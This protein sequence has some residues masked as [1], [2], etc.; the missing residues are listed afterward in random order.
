[1]RRLVSFPA[2][3]LVNPVLDDAT[4]PGPQLGRFAQMPEAI[5]RR[6]ERL[7][8]DV[9]ALA[10][11]ANPAVGQGTNQRLVSRDDAAEGVATAGQAACD[12]FGIALPPRGHRLVVD[13]T[14]RYAPAV[15]QR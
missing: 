1:V 12:R 15:V 14:A 8:R 2:E 11:I 6:N 10:Q 4:K 13:H 5:P 7:L 9:L 3:T